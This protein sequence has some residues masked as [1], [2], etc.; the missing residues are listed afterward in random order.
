MQIAKAVSAAPVVGKHHKKL[1]VLFAKI[2]VLLREVFKFAALLPECTHNTHSGNVLLNN[3]RK[4]TFGLV[5][6]S[7]LILNKLEIH[8][9][10]NGKERHYH[11]RKGCKLR[12]E[13]EHDY[14][15]GNDHDDC[16]ND[17]KQ[18]ICNKPADG[19]NIRCAALNDIAA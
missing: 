5:R 18:L 11:Y 3:G 17:F 13:R 7:E 2:S 9:R 16:A 10:C 12:I 6:K 15:S 4:L 19:V 8:E 14:C 1:I